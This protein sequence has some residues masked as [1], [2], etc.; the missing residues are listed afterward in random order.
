MRLFKSAVIFVI[1]I[2]I[3]TACSRY[4][5]IYSIVPDL[6]IGFAVSVVILDPDVTR[7]LI[8]AAVAGAV[9]GALSGHGV[10]F[11][12]L[13][14]VWTCTGIYVFRPHDMKLKPVMAGA[15][16]LC[17]SIVTN[18]VYFLLNFREL[19]EPGILHQLIYIFIPSVIYNA[20]AAVIICLI[21]K[22]AVYS[23]KKNT[24]KFGI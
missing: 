1:L 6:I 12:V 15:F 5:A 20:A 19:S 9:S 2:L 24:V 10:F 18:A 13:M 21:L 14:Y 8:Y 16:T 3:N 22:A 23:D 7:S 4:I 17:A 11:T